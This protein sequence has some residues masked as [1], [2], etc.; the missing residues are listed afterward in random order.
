MSDSQQPWIRL[1]E[2]IRDELQRPGIYRVDCSGCGWIGPE[3]TNIADVQRDF[4]EHVKS[5]SRS[6]KT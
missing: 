5:L 6:P 1:S 4:A 2:V 3:R